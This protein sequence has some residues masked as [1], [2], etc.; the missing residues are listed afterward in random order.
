M[1]TRIARL[2]VAVAALTLLAGC[3]GQGDAAGDRA[4]REEPEAPLIT[5][6]PAGY[7]EADIAF[8]TDLVPHHAQGIELATMA[9]ERSGN[10][11]LVALAEQVVATQ[12]PE[13]NILNVLL[14]QWNENPEIR[15]G[16]GGPAGGAAP[17]LVD[18]ATV[19][20]LGSLSGPEFDKLWLQ[21]MIGQHRGAIEIANAE[22]ADGANVDAIAIARTIGAGQQAQIEKM[23]QI[24]EG[25][26]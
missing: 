26:P 21:T 17:G 6:E 9:L 20:R 16:P 3:S 19:A 8:A 5:G 11:E 15:S 24:L 14:V 25:M 22:I 13:I 7:N 4:G 12:Q 23:T 18:D 10:A 2:I 1:T